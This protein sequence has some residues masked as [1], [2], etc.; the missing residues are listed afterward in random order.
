MSSTRRRPGKPKGKKSGASRVKPQTRPL[1]QVL[2]DVFSDVPPPDVKAPPLTDPPQGSPT[3]SPPDTPPA[4]EHFLP[5]ITSKP[6]RSVDAGALFLDDVAE[7]AAHGGAVAGSALAGAGK[8]TFGT[9]SRELL[10]LFGLTGL[11][12]ASDR[13]WDKAQAYWD[14]EVGRT[15]DK[16]TLGVLD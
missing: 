11:A 2:S 9:L 13:G 7:L 1:S 8:L 4:P 10:R 5:F 16:L 6:N 3:V 15:K 14:K 12:E